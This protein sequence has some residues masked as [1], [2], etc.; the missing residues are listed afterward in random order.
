MPRHKAFDPE[1][2]LDQAVTLFWNNGYGATSIPALEKHLGINRFSIYD[3]YGDKRTLFTKVVARYTDELID[4]LVEPLENGSGGFADLD[5]F[6]KAFRR[7]FQDS[8][9]ARGC[10]LVNTATEIGSRDPDVARHIQ[11]YFERFERAIVGCLQR[12]RRL[13]ELDATPA[14]VRSYARLLLCSAE[15]ILLELRLAGDVKDVAP[16]FRAVANYCRSLRCA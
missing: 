13:G 5:R 8:D 2:K 1:E 16:A 10:L 3:T 14:E 4:E 15:G 12:A 11:S 9:R 7:R 6:L